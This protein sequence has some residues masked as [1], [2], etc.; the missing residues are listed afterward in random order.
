[1]LVHRPLGTCCARGISNMVMDVVFKKYAFIKSKIGYVTYSALYGRGGKESMYSSGSNG[2]GGR[3][4]SAWL[5]ALSGFL[6][7]A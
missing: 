5:I 2:G 4:W 7:P 1:M 3:V 6:I